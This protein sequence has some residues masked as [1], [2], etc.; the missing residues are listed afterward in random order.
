M[1]PVPQPPQ[2]GRLT[3]LPLKHTFALTANKTG[4]DVRRREISVADQADPTFEC[5]GY[6]YA[7]LQD[8]KANFPTLW[9]TASILSS[10]TEAMALFETINATLNSKLP[11]D[12]PKGDSNGSFAGVTYSNTDPDCWWSWHQCTTPDSSLG[13]P[14]DIV[15]VPEPETWGLGFDDG[16]NCSHK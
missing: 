9:E 1:R 7:P 15:S 14:N 16:P 8:I 6:S 3:D 4:N 10:D 13:L 12:L 2:V 11:N 5:T